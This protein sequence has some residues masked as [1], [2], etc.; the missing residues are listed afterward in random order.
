VLSNPRQGDRTI[1]GKKVAQN[2]AQ[3]HFLGKMM[4]YENIEKVAIICNGLQKLPKVY[5]SQVAKNS[6][7]PDPC[8]WHCGQRLRLG[9]RGPEFESCLGIRKYYVGKQWS[10]ELNLRLTPGLTR[11]N[12][13]RKWLKGVKFVT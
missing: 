7:R 9:N 12:L 8:H 1:L 3:N 2:V 4:S 6:G 5:D 10:C 11:A 13:K